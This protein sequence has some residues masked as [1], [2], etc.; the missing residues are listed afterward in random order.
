MSEITQCPSTKLEENVAL[1]FENARSHLKV[2]DDSVSRANT[3]GRDN[4][5]SYFNEIRW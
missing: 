1:V 2:T 5:K 3:C 4:A